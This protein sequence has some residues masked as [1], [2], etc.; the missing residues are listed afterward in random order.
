M[1]QNQ[2]AS[3]GLAVDQIDF[4]IR[5]SKVSEIYVA[6]GARR[7]K[8]HRRLIFVYNLGNLTSI[9]IFLLGKERPALTQMCVRPQN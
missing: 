5:I 9:K 4:L 1:A 7:L 6:C 3:G 2:N 8:V